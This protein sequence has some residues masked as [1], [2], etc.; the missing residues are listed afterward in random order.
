A[1]DGAL[2]S[3]SRRIIEINEADTEASIQITAPGT[4]D[5]DLRGY[6]SDGASTFFSVR[7][8]GANP[9][10]LWSGVVDESFAIYTDT[11]GDYFLLRI[12]RGADGGVS[13][14]TEV[15]QIVDSTGNAVVDLLALDRHPDTGTLMAVG[16]R[17]SV[18]SNS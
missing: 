16:S 15:G 3:G 8:D 9:D 13:S 6:A 17:P 2:N 4:V 11:N 1:I 5:D 12:N 18:N 7:G 14:T 10:E